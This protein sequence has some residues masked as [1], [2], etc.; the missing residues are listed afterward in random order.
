MKNINPVLDQKNPEGEF[1]AISSFVLQQD[2][3]TKKTPATFLH[4]RVKKKFKKN[5]LM[6][7]IA[8]T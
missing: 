6:P 3:E 2:K 4:S 5:N 7:V 8:N 1:L